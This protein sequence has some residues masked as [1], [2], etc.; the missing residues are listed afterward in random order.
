[1]D[2]PNTYGDPSM[3]VIPGMKFIPNVLHKNDE[4]SDRKN[5]DEKFGLQQKKLGIVRLRI[6][7]I[8]KNFYIFC[9]IFL[10]RI[11]MKLFI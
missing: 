2:L 4:Q 5:V 11:D 3:Y 7:V 1:M 10:N 8:Y 9:C 6:G